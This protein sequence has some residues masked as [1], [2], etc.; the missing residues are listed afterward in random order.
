M[1]Q[2]FWIRLFLGVLMAALF[3][4]CSDFEEM[5]SRKLHDQ[6][7]RLIE[8]GQILQAETALTELASRYPDSWLAK[9]ARQQRQA[10]TQ[11]REQQD[12]REFGELLDSY[13]QVLSGYRALYLRDPA[14]L[15]DFDAS[16]Y[17]F[18]SAYLA[19]MTG[20]NYLVYL[21]LSGEDQ[22]YQ[23]WCVRKQRSHGYQVTGS[24]AKST[25]FD[26][27]TTLAE[28]HERFQVTE[29]KG[30]LLVVQPRL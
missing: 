25:V 2:A 20:D 3:C 22:G 12:S 28:L 24:S 9:P 29:R 5:Q 26:R 30:N 18:D 15:A 17:F 27:D 11:R 19:E 16:G 1:N 6:A 10:L 21:W 14:N 23:L 7:Q 4:G 8:Q 13:Q